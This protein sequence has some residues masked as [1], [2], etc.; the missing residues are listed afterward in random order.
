MRVRSFTG[1]NA[2]ILYPYF[3]V[4]RE[5][6]KRLIFIRYF[7]ISRREFP[8]P[9]IAFLR[10]YIVFLYSDILTPDHVLDAT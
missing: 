9:Q 3:L 4:K 10:R 1:S 7:V 5:N 8:Q 6:K 2:L